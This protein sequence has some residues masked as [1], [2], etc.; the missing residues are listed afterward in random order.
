M[1]AE[2]VTHRLGETED[3]NEIIFQCPRCGQNESFRANFIGTY[4]T[5]GA[6]CWDDWTKNREMQLAEGEYEFIMCAECEHSGSYEEFHI[7]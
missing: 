6:G 3:G 2:Q 4:D 5:D 7:A 1:N